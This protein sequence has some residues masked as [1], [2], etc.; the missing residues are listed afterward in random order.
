MKSTKKSKKPLKSDFS[1]E[2]ILQSLD[3][4]Y[5]EMVSYCQS[6]ENNC[7]LI[8]DPEVKIAFQ[9]VGEAMVDMYKLLGNKYL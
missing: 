8:C 5:C 7:F 9:K 3:F 6:M 2:D 4:A 1:E